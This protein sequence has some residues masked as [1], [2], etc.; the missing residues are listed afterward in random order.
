MS[1]RCERC[2]NTE[3]RYFYQDGDC[4]Y[5][6]RCVQFGRLNV[7]EAVPVKTYRTKRH[8]C[9]IHLEYPLSEAQVKA[10]KTVADWVKQGKTVLLYAACGSG[11]TEIVMKSIQQALNAGLKVGFA[12]ARRQVVLE[13]CERMKQAFPKLQVIAVCEGYTQVTDGDLI[14]CTM[15]QLYRY[16]QAFDLLIMDEVDAFPYKHNDLLEHIAHHA[17]K[18]SVIYLTA[19]PDEAMLKKAEAGD[20][21]MVQLFQ[22]PHGYPLV[23]PKQRKAPSMIQYVFLL[24]FIE[25]C[26]RSGKQLLVFVPTRRLGRTLYHVLKLPYRCRLITSITSDKERII[27][28]MRSKQ[29]QFLITTTVLERGVTFD[30]IQI[31]VIHADHAVFDEASLIQIIGRVGRN[32]HHPSGEG[33]FLYMRKTYAITRCMH[34]LEMMNAEAAV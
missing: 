14:I 8:R 3:E 5:C 30:D 21:V 28:D 6:R 34:A 22:R 7:G 18:G 25:H 13:I 12:I 29:L 10:S 2:G 11:K 15:H 1:V 32:I 27:E 20:W 33:I 4:W 26:I 24:I 19:T 9:Q 31:A 17:V 23:I 16:H